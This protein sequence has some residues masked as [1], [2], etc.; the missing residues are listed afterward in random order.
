MPLRLSLQAIADHAGLSKATVSR[1]LGAHPERYNVDAMTRT[2]VRQSAEALGWQGFAPRKIRPETVVA[3]IYEATSGSPGDGIAGMLVEAAR[4]A[5]LT[6]TFEPITKP[7]TA[8]RQRLEHHLRPFAGLVLSPMPLDPTALAGLPFPL[9]VVNQLTSLALP[10][11]IP[12][13]LA[14]GELLGKRLVAFGHRRAWYLSPS[15]ESHHSVRERAEG[16][17][18]TGLQLDVIHCSE[19]DEVVM[20]SRLKTPG[21][22]TAFIGY[23]WFPSA[24]VLFACHR[25]GVEVPKDMSVV[26]FD[27]HHVAATSH[28][29]LTV[30]NPQHALVAAEAIRLLLAGERAPCVHR[31]PVALCER[32][33][34]GPAPTR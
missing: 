19:A 17:Q 14:A 28:P 7:V 23:S 26:C 31:T 1:V 24:E 9:I 18:R 33:S 21:R 10:Q 12:D 4:G 3:M 32:L 22:P 20:R 29:P 11:V 30:V 27:D 8:W 25:H 6:L 13:D 2:K 16:L 34:D 15:Y 5:G